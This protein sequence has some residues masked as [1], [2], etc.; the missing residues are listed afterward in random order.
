MIVGLLLFGLF[1]AAQGAVVVST[2]G[3]VLKY[4]GTSNWLAKVAASAASYV[5]WMAVTIAG[6]TIL[7]GDG[8][9]MDGFG[10]VLSLCFTALLS[11]LAFL[12]IWLLRP[13]FTR[14]S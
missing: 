7:G 13:F 4:V 1:V 5:A 10:L 9:L 3:L 12:V 6:Y 8:G 14:A 11:S 2:A